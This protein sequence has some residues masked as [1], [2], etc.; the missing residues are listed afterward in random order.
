MRVRDPSRATLQRRRRSQR[1]AQHRR[2][3]TTREVEEEPHVLAASRAVRDARCRAVLR[4]LARLAQRPRAALRRELQPSTR[5]R[6]RAAIARRRR[7]VLDVVSTASRT[8][9]AATARRSPVAARTAATHPPSQEALCDSYVVVRQCSRCGS[10]P[11]TGND[12]A[13]FCSGCR[14]R[15]AKKSARSRKRFVEAGFRNGSA[16]RLAPGERLWHP[17]RSSRSS[18]R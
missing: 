4:L 5:A 14:S 13:G 11:V 7:R 17:Q 3:H 9:F 10:R 12:V 6:L 1:D 16:E 8:V 18:P 2:R 15:V